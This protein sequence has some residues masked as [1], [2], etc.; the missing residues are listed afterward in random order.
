M[1]KQVLSVLLTDVAVCYHGYLA[2]FALENTRVTMVAARNAAREASA[3]YKGHQTKLT[4]RYQ[5][6]ATY[7]LEFLDF[8]ESQGEILPTHI[9]KEFDAYLKCGKLEHGFP[10]VR[11]EDCHHERLVALCNP[12]INNG[13]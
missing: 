13:D 3:R 4:L 9:K 7:Y 1:V 5:I 8:M 2:V 11:C 12:P 10:G 6:V